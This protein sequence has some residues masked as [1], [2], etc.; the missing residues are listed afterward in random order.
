MATRT[1]T[2]T[3][4]PWAKA[5]KHLRQVDEGWRALVDRVGPCR[6]TVR[7]DRFGTLVRAIIGQ[8]ISAKAAASID[9]RLRELAGEPHHYDP[10]LALGEPGLRGVGLSGVKARYLLNLSDAVREGR[11]PIELFHDWTDEQIVESLTTIKG[12]GSWT[13]EMF[14]IFA[15]GRPDV[16]SVGDLGI[17]VGLRKHHGLLEMPTP[18]QC[19]E[20]TEPLRPYRTAAMWY[21]WE[22]IDNPPASKVLKGH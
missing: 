11:V 4:D 20:L 21:L 10:L 3:S 13:A 19:R 14:L 2:T 18:K 6:L 16:L 17:R 5:V 15:L 8:Q 22:E 7:P 1:K 9:R 12:V